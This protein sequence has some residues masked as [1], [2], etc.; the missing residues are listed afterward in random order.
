[1]FA[2]WGSWVARFR[3]PV[4]SVA[5]VAVI[6]AGV[7]GLGVF[8]QLTEGGYNDPDSESAQATE[9]V[10]KAFGAQGGDLVVIYTPTKVK[11]TDVPLGKR[12]R[13]KLTALPKS[14]VK[15][16]T[17]YFSTRSPQFVS[18]DKT[19]AVALV[20]LVGADDGAKL[21]SYRDVKDKFAVEG[22]TVQLAGG[23]VLADTTSTLSTE[24]LAK[25]EIISLPVVLI[26][27]LFLFGSLVAASLPVLVG[28]AAVLGS[29][30]ILHA[31]AGV[32]EVNSFAVNVASLLGLG[33][34]IDYGLFMV[35]R[36]REEQSAG[37]TPAEAVRRTVAT[38]GR[39]VVF[40]ATL[41]M[42]ALAGLLLFPQGFLKS[43]AYGGLAAVGL[44]ALLSLTL[45]PALLAILGPRVDKLPIKLPG[46][47]KGGAFWGRLA[48]AVLRRPV[49][50]ALP[51]L[52]GLIV[53]AAPI[54]GV[55]FGEADERT[56]PP[57]NSA[58]QA[59]ETLKADFPQFSGNGM[60]IVLR[61]Q[62]D[63]SAFAVTLR[64]IPGIA[65]IS[66][67]QRAGGITVFNAT[68]R[69]SDPFSSEA[70]DVVD[71][72]R[73]LAVP[74]GAEL[75]V[76]GTTARNVDSLAA[77]AAKLPWMVA[78]LVGA[79]LI[80]MFFAFGS[81]LLP[82][83]AVV[84]SAL[85]LSATFGIL[86][87]IFQDGHGASWLNVT[88]A[89]LEAGIVVLMAAVVF[90]LS[91]DYEVFLLSRMVEARA[92]G[93]STN[94]AVTA[95]LART[96]K[97][98]SAAA[99]LLIVVTGAFALSSVTTMRFV[100]VGMIVA[101]LLDATVVRMLLVPA[102]LGLLGNAS[103]WAPGPLK[104]LQERAGLSEHAGEETPALPSGRHAAGEVTAVLALPPGP[105]K[106]SAW[107]RE[108]AGVMLLPP[109]MMPRALPAGSEAAT[110]IIPK[111]TDETPAP[112]AA[113]GSAS[114]S[115][116]AAVPGSAA[117]SLDDDIVD[118]EIIEDDEPESPAKNDK[119]DEDHVDAEIVDEPADPAAAPPAD[120]ADSP[121]DESA[122]ASADDSVE[123]SPAAASPD[124]EA[125]A[126]ATPIDRDATSP[127]TDESSNP[128]DADATGAD[129]A[130][131]GT[132][133]A[134]STDTD[135]VDA[136]SEDADSMDALSEQADSADA[137]STSAHSAE[138]DSDSLTAHSTDDDFT[139]A[140][141]LDAPATDGRSEDVDSL[142]APSAD[143]RSEDVDSLD[144][145]SADARSE[146]VDSLDAPSADARSR[147]VDSLDA[148]SAD[149]RSE[150]VDSL[151]APSADARSR[152][153]A[154]ADAHFTDAG[155]QDAG[156]LAAHSA[157]TRSGDAGAHDVDSP[158]AHPGDADSLNA[159]SR[160]S[161]STGAD[162]VDAHSAAAHS[163]GVGSADAPS[164]N[165]GPQDTD[166]TDAD[167]EDVRSW[168][169][170]PVAGSR[171]GA[172][173]EEPVAAEAESPV[174]SPEV[175][176]EPDAASPDERRADSRD[177]EPTGADDTV[178]EASVV[179]EEVVE[180]ETVFDEPYVPSYL[181]EPYYPM[182]GVYR[183][184]ARATEPD[185]SA[186]DDFFFGPSSAGTFASSL[187]LP[188]TTE[189]TVPYFGDRP[190]FESTRNLAEF[191]TPRRFD[192]PDD[193]PPL[194][195][196]PNRQVA[197]TFEAPDPATSG[198]IVLP[199]LDPPATDRPAPTPES[200]D[201]P[202]SAP[203]PAAATPS[204]F[205][206]PF[207]TPEATADTF[208]SPSSTPDPTPAT[209]RT[210][211]PSLTT[212]AAT[213]ATP[214]TLASPGSAS[215]P[216]G[217]DA[218]LPVFDADRPV[219]DADAESAGRFSASATPQARA[220]EA[221]PE[222]DVTR[223]FDAPDLDA[224]RRLQVPGLESTRQLPADAIERA[225]RLGSPASKP[226]PEAGA[227]PKPTASEAERPA[228]SSPPRSV[229][230]VPGAG[231]DPLPKRPTTSE[232]FA[233]PLP[234]RVPSQRS[235]PS[236]A[237][238]SRSSLAEPLPQRPLL[239][240][241]A[242]P[243]PPRSPLS[244]TARPS[245]TDPLPQRSPFASPTPTEPLPQRSPFAS[246]APTDSL[247]QRSPFASPTPTEPLPQRTPAADPSR[248]DPLPRRAQG[249]DP[250]PTLPQRSPAADPFR[251]SPLPQ[252]SANADPAQG[253]PA[254]PPAQR[255]PYARPS[256]ADSFPR[257]LPDPAPAE[258]P[259][260]RTPFAGPTPAEPPAQR[261]P[262]PE[263][264][265]AGPSTDLGNLFAGGRTAEPDE[266]AD[267][268][269][270]RRPATLGDRPYSFRPG[271][272]TAEP[273]AT[274]QPTAESAPPAYA[275][276]ST[277]R[278][279]ADLGDHLRETRP[280]DLGDHLRESRP[281]DLAQY[282]TR[283]RR[284]TSEKP[285]EPKPARRPAT[286]ADQLP[287]PRRKADGDQPSS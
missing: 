243:L 20:T 6:S 187:E 34:A 193:D 245:A 213:A 45:L 168:D 128:A 279:P 129:S 10:Q 237:E 98:I 118:A 32:H 121:G 152:D 282:S 156:S 72:I 202:D 106:Y 93:A 44:A 74:N 9:A 234:R 30:G 227:Q 117:A 69:A 169:A 114:A 24:D 83:K 136:R 37:R 222:L 155:S 28:G 56:L 229:P 99:L 116:S 3:W 252:R 77:T 244:D 103:W 217:D 148:P 180:G 64:Q 272:D 57:G 4:L 248:P 235:T 11:I 220:E 39:T 215:G 107:D 80:L 164:I 190:D 92:H 125:A 201:S 47:G 12:V 132:K 14:A 91:T 124:D 286:L 276:Q 154:S 130:A 195:E 96:G 182:P 58:R 285:D 67:A 287:K 159:H 145:P 49:V 139:D 87:W 225:R 33:M 267:P 224:T 62:A 134:H 84:M 21:E 16:S 101:L 76:G 105:A 120:G 178:A 65:Q 240:P 230:V 256:V 223:S 137:D 194:F 119:S 231:T 23:V 31:I 147:D 260:Q 273:T 151:D 228:E 85:S 200:V 185:Y 254:E 63:T 146:D 48:A 113:S 61:G 71:Q 208:A 226:E 66:P 160:D 5:L 251:S 269:P 172:A 142:D 51:I 115:G 163:S 27:L 281:A 262:F 259:A 216:A 95:G 192:A 81:I 122:S 100:G 175:V 52:A 50:V 258:P 205:D 236:V 82:I 277:P 127:V 42:T 166:S 203:D 97:V 247:P 212:P 257:R 242:Q 55:R 206:S 89:P 165:D 70:R 184:E 25:A 274:P 280:A 176:A 270:L 173:V 102:V 255:S 29:L 253:S 263:P 161:D 218:D 35:G 278:R 181:P 153:V 126:A 177:A 86:V 209:P 36:F 26:L 2:G 68:L 249:A 108:A 138:N 40:S 149:A 1:M 8:G 268:T 111:I 53:L 123:A 179:E 19:S 261:T 13:D 174:A 90:G 135:S 191:A 188:S 46:R 246:P 170:D 197:R 109:D 162:S 18:K 266:F 110:E 131:A 112:D 264:T 157:N 75:L 233:E 238:P 22:A 73:S 211:D 284:A 79:T 241:A 141:S 214:D 204:A 43:L 59:I 210:F 265:T 189:S 144:A 232:T 60:P 275:A 167:S 7:W 186:P 104:R 41:L 207:T 54:A 219:A 198:S 171:S 143:A 15:G 150:D 183:S 133:D 88:P 239:P 221:D 158:P 250:S 17:S 199:D 283:T 78:M 196:A 38:A 94:E 140:D 271:Q